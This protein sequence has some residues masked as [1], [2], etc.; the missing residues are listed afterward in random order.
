MAEQIFAP[1]PLV[2]ER[3]TEVACFILQATALRTIF[4]RKEIL[5]VSFSNP[6]LFFTDWCQGPRAQ[7]AS[8]FI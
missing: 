7:F 8:L 1:L 6:L 4:L 2:I 5:A 3:P